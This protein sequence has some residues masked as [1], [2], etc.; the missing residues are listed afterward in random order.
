[1]SIIRTIADLMTNGQIDASEVT[2]LGTAATGDV[3][4]DVQAQLVSGTNIKTVNNTSLLGSGD[5]AVGGG[6]WEFVQNID[7][8][9]TS[10][11]SIS[12][13]LTTYYMYRIVLHSIATSESI[14]CKANNATV[15]HNSATIYNTTTV[16]LTR[17]TNISGCY[18]IV[19]ATVTTNN[20]T[21]PC[22]AVIDVYKDATGSSTY[23]NYVGL[24]PLYP[25]NN[26]GQ[27][28]Y[29]GGVATSVQIYP[30]S[31]TI[32]S[33]KGKVYRMKVS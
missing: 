2:G 31:G 16:N 21:D 3:G 9:N 8:A 24:E 22:S 20:L 29:T 27:G 10:S 5:V 6:A 17:Y 1:M 26:Q 13:D 18:V 12:T 32:S 11:Y 30:N 19:G 7:V 4:T 28:N 15:G 33:L 23:F 14:W 25:S